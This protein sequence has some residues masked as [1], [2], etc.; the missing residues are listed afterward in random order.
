MS[1]GAPRAS[2]HAS[3]FGSM[4]P[5][6]TP[7]QGKVR[8]SSAAM[9]HRKLALLDA[10]SLDMSMM[11]GIGAFT[12]IPLLVKELNG[13]HVWIAWGI[14]A[15]LAVADGL[16]WCELA[17]ALPGSGGTYHF[18]HAAFGESFVGRA[19]KFLFV[20]QFLL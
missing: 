12:T 4:A 18:Y 3:V 2:V 5:E 15:A 6:G 16:V 10:V 11:V 1:A 14:G 20:W 17:A 19:S 9:L 13:P 8:G 7:K